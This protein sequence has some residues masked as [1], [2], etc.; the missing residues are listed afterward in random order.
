M[1]TRV[2]SVPDISCA[3]CER[4][5]TN[6]LEPIDGI[7]SVRVDIPSRLVSV[8]FDETRVGLDRIKDLLLEEEYPVA[9]VRT[10]EE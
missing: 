7:E 6:A 2:L 9:A 4:A 5:I 8:Q 3:H 10:E 1:T